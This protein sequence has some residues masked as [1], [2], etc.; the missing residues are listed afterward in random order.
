[1]APIF[2]IV[3]AVAH[4]LTAFGALYVVKPTTGTVCHGGQPCLVE[5]LDDGQSPLLT[6]L[7]PCDV[8]LYSGNGD[9]IQQIEPV[10]VSTSHS[11]SFTPS[12]DAGPNSSTY[13]VQFTS[14]TASNS[15]QSLVAFSPDFSLDRM[16]GSFNS[17]VPKLKSTIP[18]PLSVLS[19][20]SNQVSTLQFGTISSTSTS[21]SITSS[22]RPPTSSSTPHSSGPSLSSTPPPASTTTSAS[23]NAATRLFSQLWVVT[24]A[25][26]PFIFLM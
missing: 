2:A 23:G 4:S 25:G 13:Y 12:P 21:T 22:T 11:L 3:T 20:H 16:T 14:I 18:V 10:D 17:P 19:A 15:S 24:L 5:W 7:G 8:A 26:L 1:V 9:L 6:T